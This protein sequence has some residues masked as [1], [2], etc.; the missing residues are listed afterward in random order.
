MPSSHELVRK[1]RTL[2][3]R[4]AL[5]KCLRLIGRSDKRLIL[6][7]MRAGHNT[8]QPREPIRPP[9]MQAIP[10]AAAYELF[11]NDAPISIVDK[12]RVIGGE[13][14]RPGRFFRAQAAENHGSGRWQQTVQRS[15]EDK[16]QRPRDNRSCD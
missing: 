12:F 13:Y 3:R 7:L 2:I 6:G 4:V 8:C 9:L 16:Q 10:I 11:Q 14:R 1:T 15:V 5:R